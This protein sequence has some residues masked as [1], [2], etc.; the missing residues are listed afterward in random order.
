MGASFECEYLPAASK[1]KV[2]FGNCGFKG[3][4]T[5]YG[6]EK[7]LFRLITGNPINGDPMRVCL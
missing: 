5:Y 2:K 1:K 3:V 7:V 4:Y 6:Y